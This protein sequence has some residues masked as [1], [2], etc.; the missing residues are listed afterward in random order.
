[1]GINGGL[2]SFPKVSGGEEHMWTKERN[3]GPIRPMEPVLSQRVIEGT[4]RLYQVKWDGVRALAHV[5]KGSVRLWNRRQRERTETYP[6]LVA[7]LGETAA[8]GA[9][10]DGEVIAL[11][12]GT[13][14][15]DFFRV[16]KRD[17]A[18]RIGP[19]LMERI[20]VYYVVF[21]LI[22]LDGKWL[23]D[24]PLEKRLERLARILPDSG[25]I[26]LCDSY[27]DGEALWKRTGEQGLEGIVIKE[28]LGRYHI[29]KKHPTWLKVKHFRQLEA[30]VVGVTLRQGRVNS[31]LLARE[32]EGSFT[33]IGRASSGLDQERIEAL[34]RVLPHIRRE[35]PPLSLTR[36]PPA[37]KIWVEPLLRA[38]IRF[39]EWTPDGT[40]RSPSILSLEVKNPTP[41]TG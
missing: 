41:D 28:R 1:M 37:A 24:Q 31:L 2:E 8:S 10:M 36:V 39:L 16:L 19:G 11:D 33:Y 14:K 29:G 7:A 23:T 25:R 6:E 21:D 35:G 5:K 40:L 4:D 34:T 22:Y 15:P 27:D 3:P 38:Q 26:H 20:P 32:E 9:L 30:V 18:R 12:P 13:G 17:L